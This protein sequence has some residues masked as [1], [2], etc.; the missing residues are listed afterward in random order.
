VRFA[1]LWRQALDS[2][3]EPPVPGV[4][5]K[6]SPAM[7]SFPVRGTSRRKAYLLKLN[8]AGLP[9]LIGNEHFCMKL[10]AACGL[11]VARTWLVED[12]DGVP[13]SSASTGG[14]TPPRL[15]WRASTWRTAASS[16]TVT[17]PTSTASRSPS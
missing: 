9:T 3:E 4:Q 16:S 5:P 11:E 17:R 6:L 12:R 10:A 15:G 7:V 14:G 1:E 13:G 2:E 8:P